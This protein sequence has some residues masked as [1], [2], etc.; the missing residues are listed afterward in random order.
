MKLHNN[1][2]MTILKSEFNDANGEKHIKMYNPK[3]RYDI[4]RQ[5]H[6]FISYHGGTSCGG[7]DGRNR[8]IC[9][10]K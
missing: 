6:S 7:R 8:K 2:I 3:F 4:Y 10:H 9:Y 1:H 5:L